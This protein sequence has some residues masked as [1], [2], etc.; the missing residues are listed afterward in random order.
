MREPARD[1]ERLE[2]I[3]EACQIIIE[4]K[5]NDS[6]D[7]LTNNPIKFYGYVKLVEIIGEAVYKMTKEYK[8]NHP[9][10]PWRM[11]EGMRHVLVHDYYR[12]SPEKLWNTM[13]SDIPELVPIIQVLLESSK[14]VG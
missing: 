4:Q 2:N 3:L 5:K 12:I 10:I 7:D 6:L 13:N 1:K 11:M 9:E 8:A 14:S